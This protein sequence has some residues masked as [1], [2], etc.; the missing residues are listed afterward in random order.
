[1]RSLVEYQG[2]RV[3]LSEA[4]V[5]ALLAL[6]RGTPSDG[7]RV[8]DAIMPTE[9]AGVYWVRPLGY[10][11]RLALPS[12]QV[13]DIQSRFSFQRVVA[14][15]QVAGRL[16]PLLQTPPVP[17]TKGKFLV[18]LIATA[19]VREVDTIAS[20]GLAKGYETQ[21]FDTPP[22]PGAVD[23]TTHLRRHAGRPDR[24]VTRAQRLT[25]DIDCNRA[26]AAALHLLLR[27][28]LDRGVRARVLRAATTF[29]RIPAAYMP[30]A[31]VRRIRL[32]RLTQR[33]RS[34][35]A[36]A[37]LVLESNAITPEGAEGIGPSVLF[38]MPRVWEDCVAAWVRNAWPQPYAVAAPYTFSVGT[39]GSLPAVADAIVADPEGQVIALYD[40]KYKPTEQ[41]PA[42]A[43]VYQMV[44]YCQRLK[45][46]E[47]TLVY[48]FMKGGPQEV[49]VANTLV[50][51]VGV[52]T[53]RAEDPVEDL[54]GWVPEQLSRARQRAPT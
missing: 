1:M 7:A 32:T 2:T 37:A 49:R 40:A 3:E 52:W 16:P 9:R 51:G 54:A 21:Q 24:L 12:G 18:E 36:L 45:L 39:D 28:P 14:L 4:D 10:V 35:L 38:H 8:I 30:A 27:V 26:L 5:A 20:Q 41:W 53:T 25:T 15:L 19:L 29:G 23:V 43:D 50:R 11:G 22:L 6:T 47:A 34:A 31:A 13:L 46:G 33:Y 44:T 17:A 48:P 42:R